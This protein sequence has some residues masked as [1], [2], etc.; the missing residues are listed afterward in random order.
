MSLWWRKRA[1]AAAIAGE[2]SPRAETAL[3]THLASCEACRRRYDEQTLVAQSLRGGV[4]GGEHDRTLGRLLLQLDAPTLRPTATPRW[5]WALVPALA[6]AVAMVVWWP[7]APPTVVWRGGE[8]T[9]ARGGFKLYAKPMTAD[10]PVRLVGEVPG[11]GELRVRSTEW[12]Q[13][14]LGPTTPGVVVAVHDTLPA[15]VLEATESKTLAP[16]RWRLHLVSGSAADA[17]NG[18]RRSSP[19]L[20]SLPG[21]VT[22]AT[23]LLWVDP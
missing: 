13:I 3:R 18:A 10:A 5:A 15:M 17:L 22:R 12:V 7:D 14:R 9:A 8:P 2:L 11:S 21:G 20:S 16:G 4:S 6:V 1:I 23:A 19:A